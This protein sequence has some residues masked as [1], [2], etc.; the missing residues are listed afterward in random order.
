MHD[1]A[2]RYAPANS[3]IVRF[4]NRIEKK[5]GKNKARVAAARCY[6]SS[7]TC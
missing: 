1:G 6:A 4:Y 7:S 5:R 2:P 3:C